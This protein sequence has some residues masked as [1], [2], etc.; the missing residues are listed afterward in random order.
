MRPLL[1]WA[2]VRNESVL[3]CVWRQPL[4]TLFS[5]PTS[6]PGL[7][8]NSSQHFVKSP[9]SPQ[10]ICSYT[11]LNQLPL[12]AGFPKGVHALS[13]CPLLSLTSTIVIGPPVNSPGFSH[14]WTW[15]WFS[16]DTT[17]PE[18]EVSFNQIICSLSC[19]Y[20]WKKGSFF[21]SFHKWKALNHSPWSLIAPVPSAGVSDFSSIPACPPQ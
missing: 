8:T 6:L 13:S 17:T 10:G 18:M 19:W 4:F 21:L 14:Q 2:D 16:R 3:Q 7:T 9:P 15:T 12:T 20:F 1:S 11:F 5:S